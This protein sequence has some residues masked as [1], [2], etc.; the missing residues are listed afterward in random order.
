MG[1]EKKDETQE[2]LFQQRRVAKDFMYKGTAGGRPVKG[3]MRLSHPQVWAFLQLFFISFSKSL[4]K[5]SSSRASLYLSP[6]TIL[7]PTLKSKGKDVGKEHPYGHPLGG[8][9]LDSLLTE[10]IHAAD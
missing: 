9:R 6:T 1:L 4:A 10:D 7:W 3:M 8:P 2:T 5:R